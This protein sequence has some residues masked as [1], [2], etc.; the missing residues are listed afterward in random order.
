MNVKE[1]NRDQL[2]ILKQNYLCNT[3]DKTYWSDLA[4]A[5]ELV[6]DKIIFERYD[7]YDFVPED[8]PNI[9]SASNDKGIE[10]LWEEFEDV[11]MDPETECMEEGFMHFPA[12]T[13]RKDI[14]EWFDQNHSRGI[15]YLL[16][17]KMM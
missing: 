13:P 3:Q 11:P 12:G 7:G 9:S 8:F 4:D 1:L 17:E 14:W 2:I 16:Y 15:Y 10:E 5:D 6:P